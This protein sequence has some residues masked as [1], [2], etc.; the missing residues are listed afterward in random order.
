LLGTNASS[1]GTSSFYGSGIGNDPYCAIYVGPGSI[2][3]NNSFVNTTFST[4][5]VRLVQ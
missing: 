5:R 1:G 2:G 3:S 4:T